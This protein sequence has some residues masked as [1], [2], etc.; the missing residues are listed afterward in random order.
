[1][2][3]TDDGVTSVDA[4][5]NPATRE[6]LENPLVRS[7]SEYRNGERVL[8]WQDKKL[9]ACD[10]YHRSFPTVAV[11]VILWPIFWMLV[12]LIVLAA[13]LVL[14]DVGVGVGVG[15]IAAPA[16]A[17]LAVL[18]AV[19]GVQLRWGWWLKVGESGAEVRSFGCAF[20]LVVRIVP[21]LGTALA[22]LHR[23]SFGAGRSNVDRVW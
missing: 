2:Q 21:L 12:L 18:A 15:V 1:M 17:V 23:S 9:Y 5:K 19:S 6:L 4:A 13:G 11:D 22:I 16:A 20:L 8:T 10:L 3:P 14:I 7:I